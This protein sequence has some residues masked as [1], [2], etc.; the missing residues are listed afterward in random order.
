MLKV[1]ELENEVV[2]HSLKL[3]GTRYTELDQENGMYQNQWKTWFEGDLFEDVMKE[4]APH[5]A[6]PIGLVAE[7]DAY[8]IG[9]IFRSDAPVPAS[10][11]SYP[12]PNGVLVNVFIEGSTQNGE[13]FE[14]P[15]VDF[16][17]DHLKQANVIEAERQPKVILERYEYFDPSQEKTIMIIGF[18]I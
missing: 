8:W 10:Y 13:L 16:A 14:T 4:S 12:L 7:D 18:V 6:S 5:Y 1:V 11:D 3:I 9:Q 2:H 17:W 15:L